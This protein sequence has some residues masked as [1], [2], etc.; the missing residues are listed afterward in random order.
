MEILSDYI[1][2][3]IFSK[4]AIVALHESIE[5]KRDTSIIQ[6]SHL[7]QKK[8]IAT[9]DIKFHQINNKHKVFFYLPQF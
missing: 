1:S 4:S 2:Y 9:S 8:I 6:Y 5:R 7:S 3:K